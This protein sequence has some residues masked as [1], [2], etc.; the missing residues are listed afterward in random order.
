MQTLTRTSRLAPLVALAAG[1]TCLVALWVGDRPRA[2]AAAL[3]LM[4]GFALALLLGGRVEAVRRLRSDSHDG[5]WERID[6]HAAAWAGA[7]LLGT[8]AVM[9]LWEWAHGRDASPYAQ[10][11]AVGGLVY[12]AAVLV[13]RLRS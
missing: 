4:T 5:Y 8:I 7:A 2:G 6:R 9:C 3:V 12:V 1:A 13:R 11:G 10:L